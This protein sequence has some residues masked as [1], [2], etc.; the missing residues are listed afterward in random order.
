M[1]EFE[2]SRIKQDRSNRLTPTPN[3][4]KNLR[5]K[6]KS[7]EVDCKSMDSEKSQQPPSQSFYRREQFMRTNSELH[8][9]T[10]A[11]DPFEFLRSGSSASHANNMLLSGLQHQQSL[12]YNDPLDSVLDMSHR[13]MTVTQSPEM[14]TLL[15][16]SSSSSSEDERSVRSSRNPQPCKLN[17]CGGPGPV[18]QNSFARSLADMRSVAPSV[19]T[20]LTQ[21]SLSTNGDEDV[22]TYT[23]ELDDD[24]EWQIKSSTPITKLSSPRKN[25]LLSTT[26]F[27][28]DNNENTTKNTLSRTDTHSSEV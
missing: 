8:S 2:A 23:S 27:G 9:T 13:Q 1:C 5:L 7:D 25:A 12:G 21:H 19:L 17:T 28:F 11:S 18:R 15:S 26:E 6:S 4:E 14:A 10:L 22:H 3:I 20:R 16:Q 24:E